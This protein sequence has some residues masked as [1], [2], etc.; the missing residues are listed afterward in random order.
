[1]E[2]KKSEMIKALNETA[3]KYEEK[4]LTSYDAIEQVASEFQLNVIQE[5]DACRI[6]ETPDGM[7]VNCFTESKLSKDKKVDVKFD[8]NIAWFTGKK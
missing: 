5:G 6:Y 7:L 8:N 2:D 4:G 3:K 1:M